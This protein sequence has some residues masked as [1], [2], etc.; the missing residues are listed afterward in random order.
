MS[1]DEKQR[2]LQVIGVEDVNRKLDIAVNE[3][4]DPVDHHLTDLRSALDSQQQRNNRLQ[5]TEKFTRL[6]TRSPS[7][8]QKILHYSDL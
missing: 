8:S 2:A 6:L 7:C 4:L 3:A 1:R 5:V